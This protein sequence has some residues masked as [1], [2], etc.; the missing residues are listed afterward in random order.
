MAYIPSIRRN[1]ISIPILNIIGYSFLFRIGKVKL[2]RDYLSIGNGILCESLYRLEL[3]I[4]PYVYATLIVNTVSS[5]KRLRLNEKSSTLWYKRLGHISRQRMERLIKNWILPD[6]DFSDFD[7]CVNCFK[8]KLNV[9][10]KNAK[11]D[12]CTELL[13]VIHKDVS[14]HSLMIIPVIVLSSSFVKILTLWRLSKLSKKNLSFN[15]FILIEVVSI[16]VDMTRQDATL[17]HLQSTFR[18]EAL[19]LNIMGLR[20]G[21]IAHFLIWCDVCLLIPHYL[22]S[23][24]VKP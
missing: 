16:L 22:N 2:Y 7:T 12:K 14:S 18:N 5:T 24:R 8:G 15:K 17:D 21:G 19:M 11:A 4:L 6:L 13:R 10:I 20:K 23:C 9:K 3:S 1:L